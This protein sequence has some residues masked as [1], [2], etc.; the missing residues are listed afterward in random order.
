MILSS[1]V[2]AIIGQIFLFKI[3]F[4]ELYSVSA[5]RRV[6]FIVFLLFFCDC[7]NFVVVV[8]GRSRKKKLQSSKEALWAR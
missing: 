2:R 8:V 4:H 7:L 1:H 5:W 6:E 3:N